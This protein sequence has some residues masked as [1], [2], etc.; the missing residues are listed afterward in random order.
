MAGTGIVLAGYPSIVDDMP[1]QALADHVARVH[2]AIAND[3]EA[4]PPHQDF[5]DRYCKAPPP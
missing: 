2:R 1:E 5:I 3:V 4:M